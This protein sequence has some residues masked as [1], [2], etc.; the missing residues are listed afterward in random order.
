MSDMFKE[1][2][3]LNN[4]NCK[5]NFVINN[6]KF[7]DTFDKF[8][9]RNNKN[10]NRDMDKI[11]SIE[12]KQTP[13]D[14]PVN[15]FTTHTNSSLIHYLKNSKRDYTSKEIRYISIQ[16]D[17][18]FREKSIVKISGR[19]NEP[20]ITKEDFKSFIYLLN[21]ANIKQK[22]NPNDLHLPNLLIEIF[23][24]V[25]MKKKF[26]IHNY[27]D[28]VWNADF[29][30]RIL[31]TEIV[32]K[33]EESLKYVIRETF[34]I[35]TEKYRSI[36][37]FYWHDIN[38]ESSLKIEREQNYYIGFTKFYFEEIMNKNKKM[39]KMDQI[40]N[41]T[42]PNKKNGNL[43][44]N[45]RSITPEFLK[46]LFKSKKF[47]KDFML[48]L[49]SPL[50]SDIK[51]SLRAVLYNDSKTKLDNWI[52]LYDENMSYEN[53]STLLRK[54]VTGSKAKLPWFRV[55]IESAIEIVKNHIK[56]IKS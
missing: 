49:D 11:K 30:N 39:G 1:A 46:R 3:S 38:P 14:L 20:Y 13:F 7:S 29:V 42:L 19:P 33:K 40:N 12:I 5:K 18:R 24:R 2:N 26:I 8:N 52:K 31:K 53:L 10:M 9:K 43:K 55:E 34:T 47:F 6:F 27:V 50:H 21:L 41:Y 17:K 15:K 35:L 32:K 45:N 51:K 4:N 25:L 36:H 16:I 48:I 23:I 22:V 54:K 56:K 28:E 44:S 37:F